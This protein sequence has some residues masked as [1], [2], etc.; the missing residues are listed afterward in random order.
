MKLEQLRKGID[1]AVWEFLLFNA[2]RE[3]EALIEVLKEKKTITKITFVTDCYDIEIN[4]NIDM[5]NRIVKIVDEVGRY[6]E[7]KID[8][9][10]RDLEAI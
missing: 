4:L 2:L 6:V 7:E 9:L 3:K 1:K 10:N 5:P 8:R